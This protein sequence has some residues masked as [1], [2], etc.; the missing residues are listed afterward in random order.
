[1]IE[2]SRNFIDEIADVK[3]EISKCHQLA[4]KHRFSVSFIKSFEDT[5]QCSVSP[6]IPELISLTACSVCSTLVGCET[7]TNEWYR[8]SSLDK[9]CPKFCSGRGLA[10]TFALRSFDEIVTHI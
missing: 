7:C 6:K 2:S 9:K 8:E 10:K 1:M 5:F 3:K 4:F